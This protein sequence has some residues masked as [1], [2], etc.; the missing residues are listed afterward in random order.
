METTA[1]LLSSP[2]AGARHLITTISFTR[3][4]AGGESYHRRPTGAIGNVALYLAMRRGGTA[5]VREVAPRRP[6]AEAAA[7]PLSRRHAS[8]PVK[9][10]ALRAEALKN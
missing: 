7:A 2:P 8:V 3:H 10:H 6:A 5:P 4:Q 1:Y 9:H